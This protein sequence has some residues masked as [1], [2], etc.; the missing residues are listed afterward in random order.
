[1][2]HNR[3]V[4]ANT[5]LPHIVYQNLPAAIDWLAR[6]FGRPGWVSERRA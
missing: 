1:M 6:T 5:V 2:I 4:P 3:S